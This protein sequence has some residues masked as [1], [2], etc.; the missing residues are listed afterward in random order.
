MAANERNANAFG[1]SADRYFCAADIRNQFVPRDVLIEKL[2]N[3]ANRRCQDNQVR[4]LRSGVIDDFQQ[5]GPFEHL[6]LVDTAYLN[7]RECPFECESYRAAD[8]A[9]SDD[10][11]L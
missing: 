11:Y 6:R 8:K 5:P 1:L 3:I 4:R 9:R 2:Q 10:R 7:L